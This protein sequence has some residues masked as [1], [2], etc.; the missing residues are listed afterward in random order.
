M[1]DAELCRFYSP[2]WLG[3]LLVRSVGEIDP[4][5]VLDLGSG[6]GCLT[7]AAARSWGAA[8]FISVDLDASAGPR[9]AQQLV[10][11]PLLR[12]RHINADVLRPNLSVELGMCDDSLDLVLSNPPYR[13]AVATDETSLILERCGLTEETLCRG[14]V[15]LDLL[16]L[17][18]AIRLVR[19]GGRIGLIVPDSL[20]T[21]RHLRNVR[22]QLLTNHSI[23][24][25]V[26]LPRRAFKGTDA[27]AYVIV[28]RKGWAPGP[29]CLEHSSRPSEDS[30]LIAPEL[31]VQRMD[32]DHYYYTKQPIQGTS[33]R[34]LGVT[35]K[36]GRISS[37]KL[38]T[39]SATFHTN[40][41]PKLTDPPEIDLPQ[42]E[43]EVLSS[44][45]VVC[46]PN[47]ILL[48]RVDRRLEEKIAVVR[49]GRA[50]ISDCV[51]RLRCPAGEV[52]RVV[53]SLRS[54]QGRRQLTAQASGTGA[55]HIS[56]EALLSI[57]V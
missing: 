2:D 16:F 12:H 38:H 13:S 4:R 26:Q 10:E 44:S 24:R 40:A 37:N 42:L 50:H 41:F 25:V 5:S 32:Y 54:E 29:V 28:I 55:R 27:Q 20:V 3:A 6:G 7:T 11:F 30:I 21:G 33:L 19:P 35:I 31:A 56:A 51:L 34:D 22:S 1:A 15:P 39:L 45:D 43:E 8:D 48:A 46:Q 17:A 53:T 57:R 47:D 36:R 9:A 18:Q 14:V 23:E 52:A 49:S